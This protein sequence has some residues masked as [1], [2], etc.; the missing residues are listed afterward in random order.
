MND[1]S[2]VIA[3][4]SPDK[5]CALHERPNRKRVPATRVSIPAQ[6]RTSNTFPLSFGQQRYWFLS[7]LDPE[8]AAYNVP[9]AVRLKGKLD[10]AAL[11]RSINEVV[12]RHESLRTNFN[13]VDDQLV[14][15]I[16]PELLL[17]LPI[18]SLDHLPENERAAEVERLGLVE[19]QAPFD[20]TRDALL[21]A[22][23]LRVEV[24]EHVL[25][26]TTHHIV[27]DKWSHGVFMQ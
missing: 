23:L 11:E 2:K 26:I 12:R 9:T 8:S 14:Q 5:L 19:A 24:D 13:L 20:L 27:C 1:L 6:P 10:V 25:L 22:K 7:R 17:S 18:T 16:A 3:G 4:L 21:R 15:I